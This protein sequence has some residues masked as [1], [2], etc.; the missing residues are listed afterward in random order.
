MPGVST[1]MTFSSKRGLIVTAIAAMIVCLP[2]E[3][4]TITLFAVGMAAVMA[5]VP[6]VA[7]VGVVRR[8]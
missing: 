7:L 1:V 6:C 2:S 4:E 8:V 3:T 5:I